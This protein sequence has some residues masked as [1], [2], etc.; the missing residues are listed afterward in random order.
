MQKRKMLNNNCDP[1]RLRETGPDV[2]DLQ[3]EFQILRS[4][5]F[6]LTES[7]ERLERV[8]ESSDQGF[9]EWNLATDTFWVSER[10]ESM[11]GF[12]IGER[13]LAPANWPKLVHPDDIGK[14]M[15]SIEQHTN[16]QASCHEAEIRCLTKAGDWKW[17]LTRGR[18]VSRA[19]DGTPLIISGTHTDI[20]ARKAL[21]A[22]LEQQKLCQRAL[23]D[24]L[25]LL[26]WL[27]D[28]QSRFLT[29]NT[30]FAAAFGCPT[31]E[32]LI[33]RDD[34][35]IVPT[36]LAESY[37]ADDRNV[38]ETGESKCV[39]E[40]VEF[41]GLRRWVETYK[42]PVFLHGKVIGTVG[43]ARDI[44]ERRGLLEK[45]REH[46]RKLS[47]FIEGAPVGI[48][49]FD[50][51]MRY[52][53]V[54]RRFLETFKISELDIIGRCHYDTLPNIPQ[55]WRVINQ[56]CLAGESHHCD[57]DPFV[58]LD[59]SI[60]WTRWSIRPWKTA[61]GEVGG[62][63]LFAEDITERKRSEA[64]LLA[65]KR[66]SEQANIS[67][68]R[69]LAAA[70]HD[71]RQPLSALGIYVK[72]LGAKA[73]ASDAPIFENI[74]HCV[75]SLSE[76]LT[77]LLDLSKLDAG[78]LSPQASSFGI[79]ELLDSVL[80]VHAP[81]AAQ[82]G[83]RLRCRY[84]SLT[85]RSDPVLFGRI[86]NNL[87]ANAVRY[88]ERGGIL[89]GCRKH[90]GKMWIEVWDSGIGIPPDKTE[91][92]F[93]E[94][95][96]LGDNARNRG[97]GL[98]LAIV[99]KT[100]ALL[101]L[102]IRVRSR[103]GKGSLFAIELPL[104]G[105]M[106]KSPSIQPVVRSLRVAL[107]DDNPSV[108]TAMTMAIEQMGH[109]VIGAATGSALLHRLGDLQPDIVVSDY[110]LDFGKTGVDVIADLRQEFGEALPA[111]LVTGDTDPALLRNLAN[112]GI[113]V[114]HKPI[115]VDVLHTQ[116][117][118]LTQRLHP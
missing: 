88:T 106:P 4:V 91:E 83:L 97:S 90:D 102:S 84:R 58:Q 67:K 114:L 7:R 51:E 69:F 29:V 82:K 117:A 80:S 36:Q 50:Q 89:V 42:S 48:A 9:W 105:E 78:V 115:D 111:L 71:L 98:G 41:D 54:S 118:Q 87:I 21:E 64:A 86:I 44:S 66:D 65:A 110:R 30:P 103:V 53:A 38:L 49:M 31:P 52:V 8:L 72:M 1:S 28:E 43:A 26:A 22:E 12:A 40:Y 108:L 55:R 73:S 47:L 35:D 109:Q 93:E 59:G 107:V 5:N 74:G 11:L 95:R 19:R 14:A 104:G 76:L 10:F 85:G 112:D 61:A 63:L 18:I 81:I 34:F 32:S 23:L 79:P 27:K 116:L 70:S 92:I 6:A 13:N 57:E 75:A 113:V 62:L 17:I 39:E 68:S 77:D 96:Q 100:A 15:A 20:S 45:I 99:A 3:G 2:T 24:N 33:G 101:G 25:P 16:G 37:R 46:E 94:F 56:A 60:V